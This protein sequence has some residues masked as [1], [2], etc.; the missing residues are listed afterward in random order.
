MSIHRCIAGIHRCIAGSTGGWRFPQAASIATAFAILFLPLSSDAR[1]QLPRAVRLL[2]DNTVGCICISDTPEL[3]KR[4]GETATARMLKDP[5]IV[6]IVQQLNDSAEEAF[7][8]V[9]EELGLS[10]QQLMAIPQGE[11]CLAIVAPERGSPILVLLI[12]AGKEIAGARKLVEFTVDGMEQRGDVKSQEQA[13]ETTL[14]ILDR[15]TE[16]AKSQTVFFE[17]DE[18]I[19]ITTN[20]LFSKELASVWQS[21]DSVNTLA[22][23]QHFRVIMNRCCP[24]GTDK[25]QLIYFFNPLEL[26]RSAGSKNMALLVALR[27]LERLGLGGFNG[28][29]GSLQ[30]GGKDFESIHH[31]HFLIEPP[32]MGVLGVFSPTTGDVTPELWAPNDVTTYMTLHWDIPNSYDSLVTAFNSVRGENAWDELINRSFAEK[33]GVD[34]RKDLINALEGRITRI[35]WSE[36]PIEA[37]RAGTML[38]LKLKDV[39]AFRRVLDRVTRGTA[40][41]LFTRRTERG[42]PYYAYKPGMLQRNPVPGAATGPSRYVAILG[43]YLLLSDS[44]TLL[45]RAFETKQL[46]TNP[47]GDELDFK[48]NASRISRLPGGNRPSMISFTRPEVGLRTTYEL[49]NAEGTRKQLAALAGENR[50]IRAIHE[51]LEAHPLPPFHVMAKYFAFSGR[52]VTDDDT[53][54]HS[55]G[56][57]FRRD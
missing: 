43:D 53:G 4:L 35:T 3:W 25:P 56:F 29:G 18:T 7:G 1:A 9:E 2:P 55:V 40:R 20:R 36:A 33:L 49:L 21:G 14:T 27:L 37:N 26:V 10:L 8:G 46:V 11:F 42:V 24:V 22:D 44:E 13:G 47:L 19:C 28:V 50:V 31:T 12:E 48:L 15:G 16:Q 38:G 32:R 17:Y 39:K 5:E 57:T 51:A 45:S 30:L 41:A 23:N 52:L 6:P 54:I 34:V